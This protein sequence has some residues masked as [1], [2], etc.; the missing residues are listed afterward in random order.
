[1][2]QKINIKTADLTFP[3]EL[4]HTPTA[5]AIAAALPLQAAAN[6]WQGEIY[7]NIPVQMPLEPD[8]TDLL[9]PGQLAYWPPGQAF[10]IFFGPT[11][12]SAQDE[13]RAAS[14]V[15]IVGRIIGDLTQLWNVPDGAE[16]Q[17]ELVPD[18]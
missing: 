5:R 7:F 12:A 18:P 3:A 8:S 16:I 11:P 4:N 1:M 15:S 13:I 6:R 2:S 10:C 17:V 14:N 9:E